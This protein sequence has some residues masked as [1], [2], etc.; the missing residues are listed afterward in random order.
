MCS[1]GS[2]LSSFRR[3]LN[4]NSSFALRSFKDEKLRE[5]KL[6]LNEERVK[7]EKEAEAS[8]EEIRKGQS[9]S[10]MELANGQEED[11]QMA[12][13]NWKREIEAERSGFENE[14]RRR[15]AEYAAEMEEARRA[16]EE[17]FSKLANEVRRRI[18]GVLEKLPLP[19]STQ[20]Y[21]V[22]NTSSLRLASLIAARGGDPE[23]D[24]QEIRRR[25]REEG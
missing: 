25:C 11:L 24:G 15:V 12:R 10:L 1:P 5:G 19:T 17:R 9:K 8:A 4:S 3:L 2:N 13:M 16:G 6:L 18:Y 20:F 21:N 22:V 7:R 23:H 14:R